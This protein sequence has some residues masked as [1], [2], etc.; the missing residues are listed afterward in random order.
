MS[1][2]VQRYIHAQ[3]TFSPWYLTFMLHTEIV[4]IQL[5]GF[6]LCF[7]VSS[8]AFRFMEFLLQGLVIFLASLH[9][10]TKSK[11]TQ[12]Y[13]ALRAWTPIC[14]LGA[15]EINIMLPMS[16]WRMFSMFRELFSSQ[17]YICPCKNWTIKIYMVRC[18]DLS[19]TRPYVTTFYI[20][21][22]IWNI[23]RKENVLK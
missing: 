13:L 15:V 23:L 9:I 16:T 7:E 12:N 5:D 17:W 8:F 22:Y 4:I 14:I 6:Q 21:C 11:N 2:N 10:L 19:S 3:C 18:M 20:L 1:N